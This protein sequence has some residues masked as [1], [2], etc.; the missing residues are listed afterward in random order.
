MEPE[1]FEI[2]QGYKIQK[3]EVESTPV[4]WS[5]NWIHKDLLPSTHSNRKLWESATLRSPQITYRALNSDIVYT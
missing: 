2:E 4:I 1:R 5:R 3:F